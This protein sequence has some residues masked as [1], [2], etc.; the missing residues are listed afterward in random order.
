MQSLREALEMTGI[1]DVGRLRDHNEDAVL[2]DAD[3]GV[4]VLADGM[5]GYN[6]G[7][8]ASGLAI[9]AVDETLR[10]ALEALPPPAP[11]N[12]LLRACVTELVETAITHAN[13]SVFEMANNDPLCYG[14]GTT[15]VCA[16]FYDNRV[17][18]G[19]VG[20]SR[21]YRYRAAEF[22]PLTRDH[23]LLQEQLD[24]GL[25]RP[26]EAR[27]ASYRNL[28][29]RAVG[30]D[31]Q[32]EAEVQEFEVLPGDLYLFCSDGLTDMLEDQAIGEIVSLFFEDLPLAA[33][34]LVDR[35]NA[36]GGKDN[37]S[38][39]LVGIRR[40][41]ALETGWFSRLSSRFR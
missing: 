41:Y 22:I 39:V 12:E 21:L 23:S 30:I 40:D 3:L 36:E 29:T 6:A 15:L 18:V 19:H 26:E 32:V 9:E 35:A 4:V 33:Q 24:A 28:V 5:G 1:T 20:D 10:A 34:T 13:T 37:I 14:M 17:V 16:L 2:Y 27:H 7:E 11:S 25:I 38:V 8:V 31:E